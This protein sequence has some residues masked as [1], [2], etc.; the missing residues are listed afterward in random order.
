MAVVIT[1]TRLEWGGG[2]A[3]MNGACWINNGAGLDYGSVVWNDG[4]DFG[5]VTVGAHE[6][7]HK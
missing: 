1:N 2:L 6:M 3:W 5:S 4:G 7:G